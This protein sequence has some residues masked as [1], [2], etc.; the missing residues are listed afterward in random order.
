[1]WLL[2][3]SYYFY[4]NWEPIY[5]LIIFVSTITTYISGILIEKFRHED[6]TKKGQRKAK[7][8]L[9]VCLLINL[10]ILFFFKYFNFIN[11]SVF[12]ALEYL[13][14]RW[15]I[16][17]FD[18]LLPVGISFYTFQAIGYSIDVYRGTIKAERHFGIY[19][20]F[21]SYF[22]QLVAG[23]IERAKN[24]LGQLRKRHYFDADRTVLGL[25]QMLWGLFMKVV[26][27]DRV[28]IIVNAA[29]N[30]SENHNGTTLLFATVLFAIQIYCDFAGYSNMAIGASRIMG[31][32]LMVNF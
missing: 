5:A 15:Y 26:I 18:V 24:L 10:G 21:V 9:V 27:A 29:Y 22:P 19:A 20:L 17:N 7:I 4:M 23:P 13:G 28:A 12:S 2:G 14:I 25:K 6:K 11:E 31:I 1:M 3:A 16:P 30:N 32:E 8:S